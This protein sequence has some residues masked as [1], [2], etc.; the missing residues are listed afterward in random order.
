M[1]LG[2]VTVIEL[3]RT[4]DIFKYYTFRLENVSLIFKF[5]IQAISL[6]SFQSFC[7]S[8]FTNKTLKDSFNFSR[9]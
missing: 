7:D 2:K 1:P 8:M 3:Y 4:V 5:W 9:G 6:V